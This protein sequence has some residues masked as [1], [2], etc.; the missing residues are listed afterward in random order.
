MFTTIDF[1]LKNID[2]T[3]LQKSQRTDH[4]VHDS[5]L[6][7]IILSILSLKVYKAEMASDETC[8][9]HDYLFPN[10]SFLKTFL[11]ITKLHHLSATFCHLLG[12]RHLL[13]A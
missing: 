8:V 5:K 11:R 12:V 4:T 13:F 2:K 3:R 6:F 7:K 10:R 1:L 9:S